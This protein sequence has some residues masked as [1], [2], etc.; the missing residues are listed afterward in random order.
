MYRKD[1][2]V[3]EGENI[4]QPATVTRDGTRYAQRVIG[5]GN[6]QGSSTIRS[7]VTGSGGRLARSF[8]Y[9]DQTVKTTARMTSIARKV[10]QTMDNIDE[11][12]QIIVKNHPHAPFGGF[13]CGDDID[14][15]LC[16]G[17]R[18][19]NIKSRITSMTQ[20]PTT[21]LMTISLARSDSFTYMA[22]SG[23]DGSI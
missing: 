1:R 14:V 4:I 9:T 8:V 6:G 22:Q 2:R 5:I 19:V 21:D 20:D 12:T 17:W 18:N 10:Q 3:C 23:Q 16:T 7:T 11:V 15:T 13:F